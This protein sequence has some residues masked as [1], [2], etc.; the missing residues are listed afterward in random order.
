MG[1]VYRAEDTKLHRTVALKF[2]RPEAVESEELKTRF[3]HEAEAA[4]ALDHPNICTVHEIDESDGQTFLA[5]AYIEG[6]SLKEKIEGR[7]LPLEE[8]LGIAIQIA[9]GLQAAHEK[10][11]VHRDV[12]PAN[13]MLDAEG[14]VRIMDFGLARLGGRTEITK[15]GT[16]LGTPAYMSPEQVRGERVDHRADI[17]SL[18]VL[19][20]EML[21]GQLPF[22]G[23][24]QQAVAHSILYEDY[25]PLTALRTGLPHRT[26]SHP[27]KGVDQAGG[28]NAIQHMDE[29]LVD[30]RRV[31]DSREIAPVPAPPFWRRG[32]WIL[33][34]LVL[35]AVLVAVV[36]I[37]NG[38]KPEREHVSIAVL[39]LRQ[40][41]ADATQEE[42]L[43]FGLT[44]NL[45]ADLAQISSLRRDRTH[46]STPVQRHRSAHT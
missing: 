20:Y 44:E 43:S 12:K 22:K 1:V 36:V 8:A 27:E 31:R 28:A 35:A 18:G 39:P 46:V 25:E 32:K 40:L 42:Y 13:V 24:V 11:I 29:L 37:R 16:S 5:M 23:E 41:S 30:L 3:L 9:E 17:W 7:P 34:A 26:G 6:Q 33:A 4:A 14:R 38:A 2:L 19:L 10:G 45:I 21:S 15:T